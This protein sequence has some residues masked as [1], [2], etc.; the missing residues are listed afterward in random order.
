MSNMLNEGPYAE[1]L[2]KSTS[3]GVIID[4]HYAPPPA[5]ENGNR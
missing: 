2:P 1:A 3:A 4:G 5:D